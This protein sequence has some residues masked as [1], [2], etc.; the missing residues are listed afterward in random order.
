MERSK[1]AS[2]RAAHRKIEELFSCHIKM[3]Q[4]STMGLCADSGGSPIVRANNQTGIKLLPRTTFS[5][6]S[7]RHNQRR[8]WGKERRGRHK[9]CWNLTNAFTSSLGSFTFHFSSLS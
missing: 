5:S 8:G 9:F 6:P 7:Y 2:R 3:H 1:A 4:P